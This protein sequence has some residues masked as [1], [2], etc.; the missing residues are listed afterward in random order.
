MGKETV[1]NIFDFF[2]G[3]LENSKKVKL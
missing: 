3:N 1:Q 2:D